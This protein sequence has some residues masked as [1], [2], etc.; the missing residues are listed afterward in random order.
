MAGDH[1][2]LAIEWAELTRRLGVRW[3]TVDPRSGAAEIIGLDD[4]G[5]CGS[6]P[7]WPRIDLSDA[8][9]AAGPDRSVG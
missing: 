3:T 5:R 8:V 1:L 2:Y 7:C 6:S 9:G 4:R